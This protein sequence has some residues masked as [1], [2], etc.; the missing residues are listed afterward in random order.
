MKLPK[1]AEL[2][3]PVIKADKLHEFAES[4][5]K[6][7]LVSVLSDWELWRLP[8]QTPPPPTGWRRWL[9][10]MGRGTGKTHTGSAT[11]HEVAKKGRSEVGRGDIGI[12]GRTYTDARY[13][14]VEGASG[15][16]A[17]APLDFCPRW[18]P[19]NNILVWP[20]GVRG[21]IFTADKPEG[22]RGANLGFMWADEP[23]HWKWKPEEWHKVVEFA[24]RQ[25]TAKCV[26]TTTPKKKDP[27]IK[28]LEAL[29]NTEVTTASTLENPFL[30]DDVL[31][32]FRN[33]YTGTTIGKQEMDGEHIDD[34]EGA[35]W[36]YDM[37]DAYRVNKPL[38][39]FRRIVVAIDPAVSANESS[40]ET[41]IVIVGLGTDGHAYVLQDRSGIY[42][43]LGW[44][45]AACAA[46]KRWKC[47]VIVAEV[48]NG[49]DLVEA[50]IRVVDEYVKYKKVHATRGKVV[51]AEPVV[52]L[53]ERGLVH[54]V[55]VFEELEKQLTTWVP[56]EDDDSPDRLD[57]LVWA[58]HELFFSENRVGPL[59]AYAA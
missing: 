20:N 1:I 27:L 2:V 34:T 42:S 28:A 47:D 54:H 23:A 38:V 10:R 46:Y 11:C 43:P 51:R 35:L 37:I 8:Y 57:A 9:L 15:I 4:L 40:D 50:N 6:E 3:A 52:A 5:S 59:S 53:Y 21:R 41:G 19:G 13:T 55:E 24:L 58:L 18:E 25:G 33:L 30:P 56:A 32:V 7:E 26:L 17:T 44:A 16:L 39:H 49:G 22:I 12:I 45:R 29:N 48:N 36:T 14:M 31:D